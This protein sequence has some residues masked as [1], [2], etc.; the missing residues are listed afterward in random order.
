[1]SKRH[2]SEAE[3]KGS[4]GLGKKTLVLL[5]AILILVLVINKLRQSDLTDREHQRFFPIQ[6]S[7]KG[8]CFLELRLDELKTRANETYLS[9]DIYLR[10]SDVPRDPSSVYVMV[11]DPKHRVARYCFDGKYLARLGIYE[12]QKRIELH[13]EKGSITNFPFDDLAFNF[14]IEVN[15]K[16]YTEIDLNKID[17]YQNIRGFFLKTPPKQ[18]VI[19]KSLC[20]TFDLKRQPFS[21][22]LF[23]ALA[24]FVVFY[25]LIIVI[26]VREAQLL[27]TSMLTFFVSIWSLREV[28]IPFIK[29]VP[30]IADY[31]FLYLSLILLLLVCIKIIFGRVTKESK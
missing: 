7:E 6:V 25:V 15:L 3:R 10:V 31:F 24:A 28:L 30:C 19:N 18:S 9:S 1:M 26:W 12:G 20:I 27:I 16:D 14:T 17:F 5:V 21:K 11:K 2:Q 29:G 22:F 23:W 4:Y 8:T 13:P